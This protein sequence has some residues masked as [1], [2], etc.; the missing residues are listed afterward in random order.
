MFK[1]KAKLYVWQK[2]LVTNWKNIMI[3]IFLTF[4]GLAFAS[5]AIQSQPLLEMDEISHAGDRLLAML[6]TQ[7]FNKFMMNNDGQDDDIMDNYF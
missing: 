2:R 4:Y 1:S 5:P 3:L 7:I 6:Q